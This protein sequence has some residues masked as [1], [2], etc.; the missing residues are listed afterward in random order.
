[1]RTAGSPPG[2]SAEANAESN[3][4][5]SDAREAAEKTT[6]DAVAAAER[7]DTE[8]A[9]RRTGI[10]EDFEIAIQARRT[11]AHRTIDRARAAVR[12]PRPSDWSPRPPRMPTTGSPPPPPTQNSGL[13]PRRSTPG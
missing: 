7:L 1:M 5:V 13:P 12:L 3:Q 4:T 6:A 10:E 11:E 9:A 2:C 8:S